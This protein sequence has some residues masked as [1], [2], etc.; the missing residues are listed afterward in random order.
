MSIPAGGPGGTHSLVRGPRLYI[1]SGLPG[2][3]KT[4]LSRRLAVE[5]RAMHIRIDTIE[6]GLRDLCGVEVGGEGYRLAYRIAADN[7]SL[8][9][10]VVAD[11]C[12]PIELTRR[13]WED[14]ARERG[15]EFVNVEVV[16]SDANEHRLR[17]ES[18]SSSI[19]NLVLP[20][21]Q[22]VRYASC[23]LHAEPLGPSQAWSPREAKGSKSS[24][25]HRQSAPA[26]VCLG[27]CALG[28]KTDDGQ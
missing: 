10:S 27:S 16:C 17:V 21:W 9:I 5:L 15:V 11:C 19:P 7:L 3:G 25:R 6:Q 22:E 4:T 14:V 20:T 28:W 24:K 26:R 12:N 18:R 23:V 1:F 2:S 8:G 13:E